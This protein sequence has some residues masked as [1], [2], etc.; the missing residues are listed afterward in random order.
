MKQAVKLNLDADVT[1]TFKAATTEVEKNVSI[2]TTE[3]T[4]EVIVK[5]ADNNTST[6]VKPTTGASI[7]A[8]IEG[9]AGSSAGTT[10]TVTTVSAIYVTS[11]GGVVTTTSAGVTV[12]ASERKVTVTA[13]TGYVFDSSATKVYYQGEEVKG[14]SIITTKIEFAVTE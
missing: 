10:T 9:E 14:A 6:V 5:D 4:P 12:A 2:K 1:I 13:N 11:A 7:S 8:D 3:N